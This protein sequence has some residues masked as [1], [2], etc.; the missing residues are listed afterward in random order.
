MLGMGA[1]IFVGSSFRNFADFFKMIRYSE[2]SSGI[3]F[4]ASRGVSRRK[5]SQNV[6]PQASLCV[7]ENIIL[8]ENNIN[9]K[10]NVSK[11]EEKRMGNLWYSY[12]DPSQSAYERNFQN[13]CLVD[14]LKI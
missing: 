4:P 9:E 1:P 13:G 14:G 2:N 12:L 10:S 7:R 8:T 11:S 3:E 6:Y 5:L